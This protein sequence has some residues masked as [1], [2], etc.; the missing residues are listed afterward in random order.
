M[1]KPIVAI[2]GR[3]NVGKSTLFNIFAN[4]RISIVEDTP[5]VTRDRLYADT[6][7]L[8]NEFMMVDTGGI[9]IMNTDKIAVSIRQQ[10]QIAIAEADVILFVCDARAGITHEDAEVAKMLRQSKKPIVLAINKAD[11]P[12]QEMEIF[13]FYNLGIGEPIPV[14]AANHLGLGDLLDAVVEKFPETSAYGEDGNEDE[15]KVALIGRPNVGKSS[16]FNTLVGEERSIVSD[17]AGTTRD[18]IDTPVIR[19]GQKFLFIDTAGMRRKARID[20]PIEKY[21]IIRSLRAVDR[22]D[23]VLMVI[24]AIDGVT[25]QDKKIAGYAHEA[26]KGIVLVVNKWDLYDKDNTSTLRYTENLRRELVFMQYAP[27]VFVSA[28]TKQ[29]IHRLPEVIHYVAEQNAMRISTS[30][31]NQ[32]V[33]DAIAINP[34]PTEKGQRLKIL[35]ATQVKIKPPTFVIFVNEPEIMHF[36]YQRYLENKLREAFGFEGTPLQMII[37][38]KNEEE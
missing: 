15:I 25:E 6:E 33:E 16:I 10:A 27:V 23:V 14:S 34:P 4:S 38:G 18:A 28:M 26:G 32:V 19:E 35:Y 9:E 21:S 20:E 31:L 29:R 12:K 7:W 13:E 1:G 36:S 24:D 22:S 5:G 30:V 2:V 8:D 17:V 11:S 3:P 37:R